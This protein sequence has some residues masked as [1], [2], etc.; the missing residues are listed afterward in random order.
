MTHTNVHIQ[1]EKEML[2]LFN[3]A[4]KKK[5]EEAAKRKAQ[6][7]EAK[8]AAAEGPEYV[9]A[10]LSSSTGLLCNLFNAASHSCISCIVMKNIIC[11]I[12]T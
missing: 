9:T 5:L 11:S 3:P 7:E 4:A 6:E 2:L 12:C 10:G 8:K 1:Q